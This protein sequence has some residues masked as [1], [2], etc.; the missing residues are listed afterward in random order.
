MRKP[1]CRENGIEAQLRMQNWV[2]FISCTWFVMRSSK[3][4]LTLV[5]W[6]LKVWKTDSVYCSQQYLGLR[7]CSMNLGEIDTS[8][9]YGDTW[10]SPENNFILQVGKNSQTP[11]FTYSS[12]VSGLIEK[13]V[14]THRIVAVLLSF[15]MFFSMSV[16]LS[17]V[18]TKVNFY[19][20]YFIIYIL[21]LWSK[22]HR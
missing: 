16:V 2:T 11:C 6:D 10:Y 14:G 22:L 3:S 1:S 15:P 17:S 4:N 19:N 12:C 5:R 21:L 20:K 7:K 18:Q 9:I 8:L 13:C